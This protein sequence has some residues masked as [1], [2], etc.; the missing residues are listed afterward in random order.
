MNNQEGGRFSDDTINS[1]PLAVTVVVGIDAVNIHRSYPTNVLIT[2]KESGSPKDPIFLG[3]Q[4]RSLD[5]QRFIDPKTGKLQPSGIAP[6][7]KL[8]E[9]DAALKASLSLK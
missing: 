3:F 6:I 5:P 7:H 8:Q 2:A 1:L 4:W 9:I